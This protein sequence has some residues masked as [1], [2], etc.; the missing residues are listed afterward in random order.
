LDFKN[1][2]SINLSLNEKINALE[3]LLIKVLASYV[4]VYEVSAE[5]VLFSEGEKGV[6]LISVISGGI[7][8]K[9]ENEEGEQIEIHHV[10]RGNVL[11]EQSFFDNQP[12][13]ASATATKKSM[14]MVLNGSNFQALQKYDPYIAIG[15]LQ[16]L[17]KKLSLRLRKTTTFFVDLM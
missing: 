15:L 13:S 5:Q 4:N 10:K 12:R 2:K 14:I 6:C 9:K 7:L 3:R 16:E 1:F 17:G 11:G 8:I